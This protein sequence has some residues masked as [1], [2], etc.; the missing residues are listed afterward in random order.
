[1]QRISGV[2]SLSQNKNALNEAVRVVFHTSR[3][4]RH[5]KSYPQSE[6]S[7][8]WGVLVF[9]TSKLPRV[10]LDHL[11]KEN[12]FRWCHYYAA[13]RGS[14]SLLLLGNAKSLHSMYYRDSPISI[15]VF[16]YINIVN[17]QHLRGFFSFF[18]APLRYQKMP[19]IG[20]SFT[21]PYTNESLLPCKTLPSSID[22]N[23]EL[24]VLPKD[25][26]TD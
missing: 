12:I 19:Y 16:C 22:S 3:G 24:S 7:C 17:G 13:A 5:T 15:T 2:N 18:L 4:S 8:S 1:M 14:L 6:R 25:T 10:N 20:F 9:K 23:L 26:T 11:W 21:H